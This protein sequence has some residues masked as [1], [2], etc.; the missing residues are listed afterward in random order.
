MLSAVFEMFQNCP[1]LQ[2]IDWGLVSNDDNVK[3]MCDDKK[4]TEFIPISK[5]AEMVNKNRPQA[6]VQVFRLDP[7]KSNGQ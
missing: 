6:N 7:Y 2:T 1:K 5:L 3:M 4:D